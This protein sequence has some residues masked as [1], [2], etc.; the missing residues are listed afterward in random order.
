MLI[1]M[2]DFRQWLYCAD[3]AINWYVCANRY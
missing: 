1:I 3:D 2:T